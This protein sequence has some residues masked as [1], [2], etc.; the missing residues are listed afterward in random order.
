MERITDPV[1][2]DKLMRMTFDSPAELA[3]FAIVVVVVV[4]LITT[5]FVALVDWRLWVWQVQRRVI[6]R[7]VLNNAKQQAFPVTL[8]RLRR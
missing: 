5:F 8:I 6:R 1:A 7:R 3:G 2:Y 4:C